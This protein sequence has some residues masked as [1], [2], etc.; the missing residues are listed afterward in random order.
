MNDQKSE[1]VKKLAESKDLDDATMQAI[2]EAIKEF[3]A[4]YA[5]KTK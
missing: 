2:N 4:Q 5:V 3:K 1:I